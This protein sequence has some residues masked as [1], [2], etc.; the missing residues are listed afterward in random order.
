MPTLRSLALFALP[1]ANVFVQA[2]LSMHA[3]NSLALKS[4]V[5][6]LL[7]AAADSVQ[8]CLHNHQLPFQHA[9]VAHDDASA[10]KL[11]LV[12]RQSTN[13][14]SESPAPSSTAAA[15]T[16]SSAVVSSTSVAPSTT[17]TQAPSSTSVPS[18]TVQTSTVTSASTSSPASSG[19]SAPATSTTQSSTVA[20]STSTVISTATSSA[21]TSSSPD[22]FGPA[23]VHKDDG[24]DRHKCFL[25]RGIVDI[26][27]PGILVHCAIVK[28]CEL[29]IVFSVFFYFRIPK[30]YCYVYDSAATTITTSPSSSQETST[31]TK[32]SSATPVVVDVTV[33]TTNSAGSTTVVPSS[34]LVGATVAVTTT[35]S[36]GKTTTQ[37]GVIVTTTNSA[38]STTIVTSAA[39]A[40][41][42]E[43]YSSG[44]VIT[45]T[46]GSS[47]FK[48]T[49][50]PEGVSSLVLSTTT[51]PN[52]ERSTLTSY[53][54]VAAT[55]INAATGGSSTEGA[56]TLQTGAACKLAGAEAVAAVAGGVF[57][58]AW[59]L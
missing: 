21:A 34:A 44:Q 39:K 10:A 59:L 53:A 58:L 3:G 26:L 12:K 28:F 32:T 31:T 15:P 9:A 29:T 20:S 2:D 52:G 54:T 22:L 45:R 36:E 5:E 46:S 16:T 51:L 30:Y 43:T 38:G 47:T 7:D 55:Q 18:T 11:E 17:Q 48:T 19:T 13:N 41:T 49:Y 4:K 6:A 14:T 23:H 1:L 57:G 56:P 42:R 8:D 33:T 40:Y 25:V 24:G 27:C 50:T 35:N 37:P